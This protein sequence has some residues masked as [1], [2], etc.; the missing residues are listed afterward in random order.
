MT[1]SFKSIAKNAA[2]VVIG[3]I[4]CLALGE[5]ILRSGNGIYNHLQE[6]RCR[7]VQLKKGSFRIL[8]LGDST[9]LLGGEDSYPALLQA[10]LDERRLKIPCQV[11]NAGVVGANTSYIVNHLREN[12]VRFSPDMAI[13]MAGINDIQGK[14]AVENRSLRLW[15]AQH[16]QV[17]RFISLILGRLSQKMSRQMPGIVS[18]AFA[19]D[20]KRDYEQAVRDTRQAV[21]LDPGNAVAWRNLGWAL[22]EV[23]RIDEAQEKFLEALRIDPKDI[24]SYLGLGICYREKGQFADA[25]KV[26][27]SAVSIESYRGLTGLGWCYLKQRRFP[28]AEAAF[29]K[30]IELRPDLVQGYSGLGMCL[31]EEKRLQEAQDVLEKALSIKPDDYEANFVM[32][33]L[34]K[35]R[36][37]N[38]RAYRCFQTALAAKKSDQVYAWLGEVLFLR[39]E[40]EQ[41]LDALQKSMQLNPRNMDAYMGIASVYRAQGKFED[42]LEVY[43]MALRIDPSSALIYANMGMQFR[44][45]AQSPETW[46]QAERCFRKALE[47]DP[48]CATAHLGLGMIAH[49]LQKGRELA[50]THLKRA[51]ELDPEEA[52]GHY[53]MGIM[54]LEERDAARALEYMSRARALDP[55]NDMIKGGLKTVYEMKGDTAAVMLLDSQDRAESR[56]A[57]TPQTKENFLEMQRILG[58]GGIKLA[59]MQYPLRS[60]APL[61]D[62][63]PVAGSK[64]VKIIDNERNFADAVARNGYQAYFVDLFAGDFGHCNRAGNM[65]IVD[66]ILSAIGPDLARLEASASR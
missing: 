63:F 60:A 44:E 7:N 58:S 10:R 26:L 11:I 61:K 5:L 57:Y 37:D 66:N 52:T 39:G 17:F 1:F 9:T 53:Q 36:A 21:E 2:A 28:A 64:L 14:H 49:D 45:L 46:D 23:G 50:I 43:E 22:S 20:P 30:V 51:I 54:Y 41:A 4:C 25:E 12:I 38:T 32:G 55:H 31:F 42:A 16:S 65:L 27:R 29:R 24:E 15:F 8:C 34:F 47:L 56:T 3:L 59:L 35:N 19:A 13:V 6:N 48:D 62:I 18:Q 40:Y 33:L